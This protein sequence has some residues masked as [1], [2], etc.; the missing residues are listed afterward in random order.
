MRRKLRSSLVWTTP[1]ASI[2][3]FKS[4]EPRLVP[5]TSVPPFPTHRSTNLCARVFGAVGENGYRILDSVVPVL[6]T[7][8][9]RFNL[10]VVSESFS[11]RHCF[12]VQNDAVAVRVSEYLHGALLLPLVSLDQPPAVV[13]PTSPVGT[14]LEARRAWAEEQPKRLQQL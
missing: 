9:Y 4:I 3:G 10:Q 12:F 13:L 5:R 1:P 2:F 8:N 11:G 6:S 7:P 14:G